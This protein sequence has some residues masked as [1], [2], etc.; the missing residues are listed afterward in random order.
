MGL[1][2][3]VIRG[4]AK[5]S[6]I[7]DSYAGLTNE[8][9]GK[10]NRY[11]AASHLQDGGHDPAAL[12]RALDQAFGFA[13]WRSDTIAR[14]E[15]Q[16][17]HVAGR[18][19]AW[20]ELDPEGRWRYKWGGPFDRRTSEACWWVR[21]HVPSDGLALGELA[22]LVEQAREKFYP[23]LRPRRFQCHPNERHEPQ[24]IP[25]MIKRTV[26]I[27]YSPRL[28]QEGLAGAPT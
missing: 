15:T 12:A 20:R 9:S 21:Q 17:L 5:N 19:Q 13:T 18:E 24:K 28:P 7:W 25:R 10:V 8:L 22:Q 27:P 16:A 6:P 4:L 14:T 2:N 11:I 26:D 1:L 23:R 3:E